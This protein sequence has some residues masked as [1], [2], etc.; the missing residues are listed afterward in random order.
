MLLLQSI[1]HHFVASS[2]RVIKKRTKRIPKHKLLSDR[3][4][5]LSQ[6][7]NIFLFIFNVEKIGD[8][9]IMI[10]FAKNIFTEKYAYIYC[11]VFDR[12][13]CKLFRNDRLT[14][15]SRYQTSTERFVCSHLRVTVD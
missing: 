8:W 12:L 4:Y 1:I 14:E 13:Y 2:D 7:K 5:G 10:T 6:T 11:M 9:K 3:I 15:S